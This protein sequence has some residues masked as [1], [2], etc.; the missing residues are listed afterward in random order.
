MPQVDIVTFSSQNF[1]LVISF[2]FFTTFVCLYFLI[3]FGVYYRVHSKYLEFHNSRLKN[4]VSLSEDLFKLY[5]NSFIIVSELYY[6][7]LKSKLELLEKFVK[8]K[9]SF[10]A[11]KELYLV[12]FKEYKNLISH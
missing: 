10:N 8:T 2:L 11:I 5:N 12:V 9:Y 7:K 6:T 4:L 1:W 3:F